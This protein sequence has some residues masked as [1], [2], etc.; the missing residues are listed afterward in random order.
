[1]L[2]EIFMLRMEAAAQKI[3]KA[4]Q[5]GTYIPFDKTSFGAFK[6]DRVR[7]APAGP[8]NAGR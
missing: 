8:S 3:A 6:R 7:R 2:A 1:M 4:A 5:S